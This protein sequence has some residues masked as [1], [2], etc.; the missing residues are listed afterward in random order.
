VLTGAAL[1]ER[2]KGSRDFTLAEMSQLFARC[3]PSVERLEKRGLLVRTQ[4]KYRLF[5]SMVAPWLLR[6][7]I[8][9][10][11]E[12]QSYEEWLKTSRDRVEGLMGKRQAA[13]L[14]DVLPK[15]R[16]AYRDLI[17]TWAS[18]PRTFDAVS[19]LLKLALAIAAAV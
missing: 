11:G 7:L 4:A 13:S 18:D 5:S 8:A 1:L 10:T 3:E 16:P 19:N 17:L 2:T 14:N 12:E 15:V 9:G 6:Q